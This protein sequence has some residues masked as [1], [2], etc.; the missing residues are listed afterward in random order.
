M[1]TKEAD[2]NFSLLSSTKQCNPDYHPNEG[3]CLSTDTSELEQVYELN[4]SSL[5]RKS[6][7]W[8]YLPWLK[9]RFYNVYQKVDQESGV[10][11]AY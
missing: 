7:T 6:V 9:T 2:H 5:M 1:L 11:F 10:G 3:D 8:T 4:M